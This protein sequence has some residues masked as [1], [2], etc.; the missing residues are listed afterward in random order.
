MR[1]FRLGQDDVHMNVDGHPLAG[2]FT[3]A[4]V[5]RFNSNED[6]SIRP[7]HNI[8]LRLVY[9]P[10]RKQLQ[11]FHAGG[12][13]RNVSIPSEFNSKQIL[14]WITI[15]NSTVKVSFSNYSGTITASGSIS[16][17]SFNQI[18]YNMSNQTVTRFMFSRNFCDF[19]SVQYHRILLA[20]KANGIYIV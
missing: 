9:R 4:A 15:H 3:I 19:D 18:Q 1:R 8:L 14:L 20:E 17:S 12:Q 7:Y 13:L 10:S 16:Q 5:F 11:I 2:D 6:F